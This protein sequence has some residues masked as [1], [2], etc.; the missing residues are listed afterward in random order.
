MKFH[1]NA[2]FAVMCPSSGNYNL[3]ALVRVCATLS[4]R[5]AG[6][7]K[8]LHIGS[9]TNQKSVAKCNASV[10]VCTECMLYV[11]ILIY[12]HTSADA[13]EISLSQTINLGAN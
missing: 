10:P 4:K 9:R 12:V 2:L 1:V 7:A 8:R 5:K 3:N 11:Y 13:V 6:R